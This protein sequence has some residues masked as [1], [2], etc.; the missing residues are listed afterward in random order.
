MFLFLKCS[1]TVVF[2]TVS[3]TFHLSEPSAPVLQPPDVSKPFRVHTDA[4][5]VAIAAVLEQ[6][7]DSA[8]HLVAYTSRKLTSA[9]TNCIAERE[10]LAVVFMEVVPVPAF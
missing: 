1:K 4:C 9:E 3:I 7:R 10:T 5:N 8:W 2:P 6:E